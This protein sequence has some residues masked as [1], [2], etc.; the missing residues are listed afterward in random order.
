M[1]TASAAV[2]MPHPRLQVLGA[3]REGPL[4]PVSGQTRQGQGCQLLCFLWSLE[5]TDQ[6]SL[7]ACAKTRPWGGW[8]LQVMT[9]SVYFLFHRPKHPGLLVFPNWHPNF[10]FHPDSPNTN[11]VPNLF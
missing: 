9:N 6:L 7:A 5:L 4:D 3:Y 1:K 10:S 8:P 2:A 11:N